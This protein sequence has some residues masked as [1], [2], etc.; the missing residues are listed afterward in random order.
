MTG[1]S[2][3][4]GTNLC[5]ALRQK[6]YSVL[7]VDKRQNTW[8]DQIPTIRRDLAQPGMPTV[9]EMSA[10]KPEFGQPDLVIHLAANAKVHELVE[11]PRRAHEN[12]TITFNVSEFCRQHQTRN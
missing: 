8:T 4:V 1:S 3:Q 7:G 5:L 12:A 9:T 11:E 6:D 2:G 10:V